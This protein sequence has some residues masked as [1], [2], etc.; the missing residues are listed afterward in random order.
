MESFDTTKC[1]Q[2]C[3]AAP[4]CYGINIFIERDP[5]LTPSETCPDP[6]STT[7]Y[8]CSLWGHEI[9]KD[10]ATNF[11]QWRDQ[12]HVVI[13]GSN[14]YFK[15]GPPPSYANFS[16]PSELGGSI[17]APVD[18]NSYMGS[19]V[20]PGP[21]DP[22]QCATSCQETTAYDKAHLIRPDGTYD[23]CNFFNAYVLSKNNEPQGTYC[24][25]Y[26]MAW[27]KSYSTNYGYEDGSDY[28]SVSQSYAYT[29]TVQDPG[30]VDKT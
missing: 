13:S 19:K 24:A 15:D 29:L 16:G 18:S 8:K 9:T 28:Y 21:Y 6:N 30:K 25:M 22:G 1:Q 26:T 17:N 20:Y 14:G 11:G 7:N 10:D 27:D 3:D 5:S 4:D 12:F 23:A 2:Y